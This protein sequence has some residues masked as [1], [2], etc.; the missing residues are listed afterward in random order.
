MH[1]FCMKY[2][3]AWPSAECGYN[4]VTQTSFYRYELELLSFSFSYQLNSFAYLIRSKFTFTSF[5]LVFSQT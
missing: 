4:Y 5:T 2:V 1:I 3:S